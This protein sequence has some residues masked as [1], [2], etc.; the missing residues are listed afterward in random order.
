M[1]FEHLVLSTMENATTTDEWS[2]ALQSHVSAVTGDDAAMSMLGVGASFEEFQALFA[3]R[4]DQLERE[5]TAPLDE[6]RAAVERAEQELQAA[7]RR[8][9]QETASL[10]GTY[11]PGY[12]RHLRR[13]VA[14]TATRRASGEGLAESLPDAAEEQDGPQ[15]EDVVTFE[16]A[17]PD[18]RAEE[19][20]G[21]RESR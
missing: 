19:P 2:S 3:Q 14:P 21:D 4:V 11:K 9:V 6:L 8:Q 20:E 16:E 15:P 17:L 13:E 7:R 5:F 12:E 10:W 1:H 18:H